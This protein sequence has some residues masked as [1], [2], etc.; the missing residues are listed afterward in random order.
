MKSETY[1]LFLANRPLRT[2]ASLRVTNKYTGETAARV[3]LAGEKEIIRAIESAVEAFGTLKDWPSHRRKRVLLHVAAG[4]ERRKE[5]LARALAVEAGKPIKDARGEVER[6]LDTF[7]LAAEESTRVYGEHMPLDISPRAEGY[8]AIWK[9]FPIGPCSLIAPFNF[10][11]NLVAHKV[12]PALAVGCSFL[13]KPSSR[14]PVT[15]LM[16]GEILAETDL[17]EGTFSILPLTRKDADLLTTDDRLKLLSFTGSPEAGWALKAR[18]GKKK[19][20]LELGGNAGCIID[21]DADLEL[22]VDRL[23]MGAFYQSGQSCISVQRIYGHADIYDELR[24]KLVE[25]A[26]RLKMGDPLDEDTFLGP[27]ISE[28]DARRVEAWVGEAVAGGARVLVGGEREGSFFQ[29]T[30]LEGV[31]PDARISCREVFGPVATLDTFDDFEQA[32]V[33]VNRSEYGLQAGVFTRDIH[34]AFRAFRTLEVGGVVVNDVPSMRVDSMP[35]GGVKDSGLGRE[36]VRFAMEEMTEIRL[37]VLR[38]VGMR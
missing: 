18:A 15:A 23:L 9:R 8:E 20:V 16:L 30:L 33:S 36:G 19:V 12:A 17:P 21:S 13:I 24:D 7:T 11:L 38:R 4:I 29:P 10:P 2:E 25:G 35:Y 6:S 34:R 26:S 27:L 14:T 31:A 37:M 32:L 5:E 22:T 1:P 3:S 28:D